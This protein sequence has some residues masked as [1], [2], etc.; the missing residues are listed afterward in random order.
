MIMYSFCSLSKLDL[1]SSIAVIAFELAFVCQKK[2]ENNF[3]LEV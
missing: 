2:F 1:L 3:D